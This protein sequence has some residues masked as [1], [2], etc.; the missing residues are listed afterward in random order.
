MNLLSYID[1]YGCYTM[2][3]V[4][5]NEIDNVILSIFSYLDLNGIVS[6][7]KYSPKK[8]KQIGDGSFLKL[9]FWFC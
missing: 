3:E 7:N 4:P 6:S 5:F 9:L 1:K 2:D 8:I